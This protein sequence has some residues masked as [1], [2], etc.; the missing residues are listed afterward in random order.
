MRPIRPPDQAGIAGAAQP[1]TY[2]LARHPVAVRDD[3]HR[4]TGGQNLHQRVIALLPT[5]QR[6]GSISRGVASID[7]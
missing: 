4:H 7:D 2:N 1:D 5:G 3:H 6:S